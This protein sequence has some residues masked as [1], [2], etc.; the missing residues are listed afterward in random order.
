M[1][2]RRHFVVVTSG[3]V[4]LVA[5]S[6]HGCAIALETVNFHVGVGET[7][8]NEDFDLYEVHAAF[9]L[10][11]RWDASKWVIDSRFNATLG[12]LRGGGETGALGTVTLGVVAHQRSGRLLFSIAA[13]LGLLSED[14]FGDQDFGGSTQA[15]AVLGMSFPISRR[16]LIGIQYRHI[17]DMDIHEGEDINLVALELG[18]KM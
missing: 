11:W 4:L 18:Y 6:T 8:S 15:T 1:L 3:L 9:K 14:E 13:G 16:F 7:N 17:S 12:A 10:P 2:Y 5:I